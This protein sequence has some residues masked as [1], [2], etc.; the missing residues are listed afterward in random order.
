[1]ALELG[2]SN[3]LSSAIYIRLGAT[4]SLQPVVV[5]KLGAAFFYS[6]LGTKV[7]ICWKPIANKILESPQENRKD[8]E[9]PFPNL[10]AN[11]P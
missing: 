9:I 2:A 6:V 7:L 10:G 1:M 8:K 11:I 4:N 5:N 3:G